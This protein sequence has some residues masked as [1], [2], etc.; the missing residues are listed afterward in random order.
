[1]MI[2]HI[3]RRAT[4]AELPRDKRLRNTDTRMRLL[5]DRKHPMTRKEVAQIADVDVETARRCLIRLRE[6]GWVAEERSLRGRSRRRVGLI[7]PCLPAHVEAIVAA[8]LMVVK[9][10][11]DWLGQWLMRNWLDVL[12]EENEYID[13]SRPSW[14]KSPGMG[15]MEL[16]RDY[17]NQRVG[18]EFQGQQHYQKG[19]LFSTDKSQLDEQVRRDNIKAGVCA[20]NAYTL[21]EV[22]KTDLTLKT[23]REKIAGHLPP[24]IFNPDGPILRTLIDI[25]QG[26]CQG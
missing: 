2:A 5:L 6:C 13:N 11:V 16:D 22:C 15:Y 20:R 26:Y 23:M 9:L 3:T 7:R 21:I 25:S 1:M 24:A 18:L 19:G 8:R 14:L 17:P 4:I 10:S 12:V